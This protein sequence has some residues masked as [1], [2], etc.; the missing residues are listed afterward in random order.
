MF[1]DTITHVKKQDPR[2]KVFISVG[3]AVLALLMLAGS[4][5]NLVLSPGVYV[6]MPE[7]APDLTSSELGEGSNFLLAIFR[8]IIIISWVFF[9]FFIIYLIINKEARKKF[10]RDMMM[11]VPLFLL[12]FWLSRTNLPERAAEELNLEAGGADQL[13]MAEM[14]PGAPL[15]EFTAPPNWVTTAA[16]IFLGVALTLIMIGIAVALWRRSQAAKNTPLMK[17]Q[18]EA[19]NAIN[20]IE[21][22][23]DVRGVIIRCYLQMVQA[24]S[25][26][27]N[28]YR[29][30]DMTPHEFEEFLLKHGIPSGPVHNLTQLF[31]QVRYGAA[32]PG[33]QEERMAITSLSAIVSAVQRMSS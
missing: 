23:G 21:A 1:S 32:T 28:L 26:S 4:L 29:G 3:I 7:M 16:A 9:P 30:A 6:S 11:L 12:F 33:R 24:V 13:P 27:R 22:G 10:I 19:Q 5:N 17:V 15:P 8:V 2:V 14:T 20:A 25:E 31:E 18:R